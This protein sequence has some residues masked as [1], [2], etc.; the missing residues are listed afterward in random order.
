MKMSTVVIDYKELKEKAELVTN[1][2][3]KCL[4][5][6]KIQKESLPLL[7]ST[8]AIISAF[9]KCSSELAIVNSENEILREEVTQFA[10]KNLETLKLNSKL[11]FQ[12]RNLLNKTE[13]SFELK[14]SL[15]G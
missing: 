15:T 3:N 7:I 2:I 6:H 9:D 12:I 11:S 5:I 4:K 10:R 1:Q 8:N 14:Q 13:T